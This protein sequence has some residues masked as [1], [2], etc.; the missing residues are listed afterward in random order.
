MNTTWFE[1]KIE[2]GEDSETMRGGQNAERKEMSDPQSEVPRRTLK[3]TGRLELVLGLLGLGDL[4]GLHEA[5][6]GGLD[7][8][9]LLVLLGRELLVGVLELLDLVLEELLG[10][11]EL[12]LLLGDLGVEVGGGEG[13][14]ALDLLLLVVSQ[15]SMLAGEQTGLRFSSANF[16]RAS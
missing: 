11:L 13:H 8:G 15:R 12:L 1:R 5:Q 2:G 14:E 10:L 4:D 9:D 6:A 7:G 3:R 16:L